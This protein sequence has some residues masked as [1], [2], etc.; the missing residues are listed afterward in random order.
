[1]KKIVVIFMVILASESMLTAI[2]VEWDNL[3]EVS[4]G[5]TLNYSLFLDINPPFP[6]PTHLTI[7]NGGSIQGNLQV[8]NDSSVTMNDNSWVRDYVQMWKN[9]VITLNDNARITDH[10][11]VQESASLLPVVLLLNVEGM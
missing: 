9:T 8:H 3:G 11:G 4:L 1:M 5:G 10:L 7:V 2:G 6:T